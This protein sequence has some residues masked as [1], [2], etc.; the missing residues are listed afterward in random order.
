MDIQVPQQIVDAVSNEHW[1]GFQGEDWKNDIAVREFI[2]DNATEYRGDADFLTGPTEKTTR[3]W[4]LV[5][6]LL[7]QERLNGGVLEVSTEVGSS[8]TSHAPGYISR[9]DEVIVGLQTD[10]PLRRAIFP[11]GGLRMVE[12]SLEEYGFAPL[13]NHIKEIFRDY[14][15]SHNEGVFD[16][17]DP[18]ILACRRSGVITGLPDAYGR[19][20]I[21]GDYRRVAL[22]G[23]DRL[24]E[25]HLEG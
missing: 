21:I 3:Q 25:E 15:K 24:I 14:R 4:A 8:I 17:Y 1:R 7:K 2:R 20:R 10:A 5:A 18:E 16:V 19:G 9:A 22:Y 11:K 12:Q 6:A 13:P 23:V